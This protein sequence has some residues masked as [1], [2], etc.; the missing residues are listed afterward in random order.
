MNKEEM[1]KV[2]KK[3][4]GLEYNIKLADTFKMVIFNDEIYLFGNEEYYDLL[5]ELSNKNPNW[6]MNPK[7]LMKIEK[8]L[9]KNDEEL[10]DFHIYY[11]P[12]EKK[13]VIKDYEYKW[14]SQSEI[15]K[16]KDDFRFNEAFIYDESHPDMLGVACIIDGKIVGMAGASLDYDN[17]WQMGVNVL[18]DYGE[19]GIESSL[20][21]LLKNNLLEMNIIPYY[22]TALS[23]I[24]SQRIA[25]NSG[26]SPVYLEIKAEKK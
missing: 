20:I 6:V 18:E 9:K 2:V 10:D 15:L 12:N 7:E 14:F 16:F 1:L 13:P 17:M 26:F 19:Q 4:L 25:V 3:N 24:P 22:G 21:G 11:L 23:H 8:I 5:N